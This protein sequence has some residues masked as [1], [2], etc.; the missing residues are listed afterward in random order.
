MTLADAQIATLI[1]TIRELPLEK[2]VA[3]SI[4]RTINEMLRL[5]RAQ[6][7]RMAKLE[8]NLQIA[9]EF[10]KNSISSGEYIFDVGNYLDHIVNNLRE[11]IFQTNL[12]GD[13]VFL[14]EAWYYAT[15]FTV[16]ESLGRNYTEFIEHVHEEDQIYL[17]EIADKE[18]EEMSQ[19]F[20]VKNK[21]GEEMWFDAKARVT[22]DINGRRD[23]TI[24][25]IVDI[26]DRKKI[27]LELIKA[28]EAKNEFLSTISHEIR[29]PLNAITGISKLLLLNDHL[30]GQ[31]ENLKSLKFSSEH[32]LR[33]INDVLNFEQLES[34]AIHLAS[35]VFDLDKLLRGL[36]R[37]FKHQ[38]ATK[39][40]TFSIH[41]DES[42]PGHLIGDS[43]RL[44]QVLLNLMNNAIK[45][46]DMGEVKL[47][48]SCLEQYASSIYLRFSIADTGI[49]IDS[50]KLEAIFSPFTQAGFNIGQ[51]FG[52]TG[53]GLSICKKIL[54]LQHSRLRV[55]SELGKGSIFYFDLSFDLPLEDLHKPQSPIS[56]QPGHLESMKVLLVEDNELNIKVICQFFEKWGVDVQLATD[57][58]QAVERA[59]SSQYDIILMDLNLPIMDGYEACKKIL[60]NPSV[61]EIPPIIALTAS[62]RHDLYDR[63]KAV[64][65][66]DYLIKPFNPS[67]LKILLEKYYEK[68]KR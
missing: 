23:G 49:G 44:H 52:G 22:R 56:D 54:D 64:G 67:D 16:Q 17:K 12:E 48:V 31:I 37:T 39:Q 21:F 62:A 26:T 13:W 15:G 27:E 53:L 29:T 4:E 55:K 24:G 5:H 34:G 11:I 14:N 63:I 30:P 66:D 58:V 32:L 65:M 36:N 45:F 43:M 40:L 60:A 18:F 20:R 41:K 19:L 7:E 8:A 68:K 61:D 28:N 57:G 25:T 1:K 10:Y 46:T 59:S 33:L 47:K 51:Q 38:A 35:A 3:V 42:I 9:T 2:K 50:Q 6:E